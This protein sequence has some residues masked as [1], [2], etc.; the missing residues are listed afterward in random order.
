MHS[1]NYTPAQ[2]YQRSFGEAKTLAFV[3]TGEAGQIN[4]WNTV[5]LGWGND[6]RKD[7]AFCLRTRRL[8]E[9]P[10]AARIRW[11]QRR[12]KLAGFRAGRAVYRNQVNTIINKLRAG[13]TGAEDRAG[14]RRSTERR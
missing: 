8:R 5:L 4:W 11:C 10:H 1:H 6:L 14:V 13:A 12:A 2:A 3:W 9:W 7:L